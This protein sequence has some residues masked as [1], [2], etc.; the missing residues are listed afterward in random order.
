M[1]YFVI[2]IDVEEWFHSNWFNP[3]EVISRYYKGKFPL[4]DIEVTITRLLDLFERYSIN[5]TFFCLVETSKIYPE[6][7]KMIVDAGHEIALHG[8]NHDTISE[9]SEKFKYDLIY[10]R[11]ILEKLCG[12]NIIGYRAPN[13]QIPSWAFQELSELGF[14]YDSSL[15]PCVKIPGWYGSS[16]IP[17][18]PHKIITRKGYIIEFPLTVF[19]ILR[20]PGSGGWFLR[21][22]G[23]KW[24][25]LLYK[26]HL[27][28]NDLAVLYLHPWEISDNN[29]GLPEIPFHV[30]RRTGKWTL[31]S[32]TRIIENFQD[33]VCFTSF[34]GYLQ[35][36]CVS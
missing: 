28:R 15:V 13:F 19:P 34:Q 17:T 8:V 30:F 33:D 16:K 27:T 7:L 23:L 36:K 1:K 10:G 22:F 20:I 5:S 21:N 11:K 14:L 26:L 31:D 12:L 4:T 25:E 3:K 32:L 2:S 29:K 9:D 6:I 18:H 24:V 35:E